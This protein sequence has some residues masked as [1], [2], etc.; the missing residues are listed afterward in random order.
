MAGRPKLDSIVANIRGQ[1]DQADFIPRNHFHAYLL[2]L[3]EAIGDGHTTLES[4]GRPSDV[5][6]SFPLD[7]SMPDDSTLRIKRAWLPENNILVGARIDSING[8]GA[9]ELIRRFLV[10]VPGERLHFRLACL[11]SLF[12]RYYYF[13][14]TWCRT[15]RIQATLPDGTI[16]RDTLPPISYGVRRKDEEVR[17]RND[18]PYRFEI[19]SDTVA[20]LEI[21]S[22]TGGVHFQFFLDSTFRLLKKRTIPNLIIDIRTSPGGYTSESDMLLRYL[23]DKHF[24]HIEVGILKY[25][26]QRAEYHLDKYRRRYPKRF[27]D[28]MILRKINKDTPFGTLDT[29]Y[30]TKLEKPHRKRNRYQGRSW[31]LTSH[32]TYSSAA[33]LSWVFKYFSMGT[34]V[35]EETGGMSVAFGVVNVFRLPNTGKA[36]SISVNK[37]YEYG[38][39]DKD[40]HGTLPDYPVPAD[41]AL[42]YTLDLIRR[43]A[44]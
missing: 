40:I 8:Q 36:Y 9:R 11:E 31:L 14:N 18:K 27:T 2:P 6:P 39:D 23:S 26:R 41:E 44:K 24:H 15:Y 33:N 42:D 19:L 4:Y 7:V 22:L 28:E 5:S 38:A 35:G 29:I 21:Q 12:H 1:L 17:H 20:L 10:W 32:Y 30:V 16:W 43:G 34:V 37:L 13:W 3:F 25:S